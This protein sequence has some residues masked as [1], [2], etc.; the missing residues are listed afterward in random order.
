M[1]TCYIDVVIIMTFVISVPSRQGCEVDMCFGTCYYD[2]DV[3][4]M[5]SKASTLQSVHSA[6]VL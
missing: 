6:D 5:A 2:C 1:R 4:M 3:F